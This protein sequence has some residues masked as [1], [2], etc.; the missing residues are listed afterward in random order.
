MLRSI[1]SRLCGTLDLMLSK[2]EIKTL[3]RCLGEASR[4][5]TELRG[6]EQIAKYVQYPKI[7]PALS[8]SLAV[9][10]LRDGMLLT[11]VGPFSSVD[12]GGRVADI[13]A[14]TAM[15]TTLRIETKAA[16]TEEF[17]TFGPKDYEADFLLWLLFGDLIRNGQGGKCRVLVCPCP[18]DHLPWRKDRVTV[19]QLKSA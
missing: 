7:P 14:T 3:V 8:E 6:R 15:G 11:H 12:L 2:P 13:V 1:A 9:H 18:K 4:F 10:A 17:A 16:G 5:V 19:T